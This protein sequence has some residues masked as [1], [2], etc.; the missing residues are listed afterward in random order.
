MELEETKIEHE[1]SIYDCGNSK[2][3]FVKVLKDF[4][5]EGLKACKWIADLSPGER[6]KYFSEINQAKRYEHNIRANIDNIESYYDTVESH[7]KWVDENSTFKIL[8]STDKEL[9]FK[10]DMNI[11]KDYEFRDGLKNIGVKF[12]LIGGIEM[13]NRKIDTLLD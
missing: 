3:L 8:I 9:R 13:R 10:F 12:E 11:S 4:T 6:E 5:G 2:L 1:L 7:A